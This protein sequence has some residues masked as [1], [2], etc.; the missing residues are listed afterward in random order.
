MNEIIKKRC[1]ISELRYAL[2]GIGYEGYTITRI[3]CD[4]RKNEII[5]TLEKNE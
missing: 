3:E 5:I 1:D 4:I 2:V